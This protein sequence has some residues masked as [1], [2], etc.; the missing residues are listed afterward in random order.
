M[1]VIK[2]YGEI[3]SALIA[4]LI[5]GFGFVRTW[6]VFSMRLNNMEKNIEKIEITENKNHQ[7]NLDRIEA[8]RKERHDEITLLREEIVETSKENR[9]E[10]RDEHKDIYNELKTLGKSL[11]EIVAEI[12]VTKGIRIKNGDT[13]IPVRK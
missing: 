13:K 11:I 3:I 4:F 10:N 7:I 2:D 1:N 5:V 9:V 12:R 8:M 6:T